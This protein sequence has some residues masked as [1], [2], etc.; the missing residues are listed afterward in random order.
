MKI[1][2]I[3]TYKLPEIIYYNPLQDADP[4]TLV[5]EP[6]EGG[7]EEDGNLF[8]KIAKLTD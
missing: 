1:E 2:D 3:E 4:P 6:E 8:W 5:F 7:E